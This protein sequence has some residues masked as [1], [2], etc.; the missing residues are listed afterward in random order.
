[1]TRL[2]ILS[3]AAA[4]VA[5]S[6]IMPA[7]AD[8]WRRHD[9]DHDRDRHV[10]HEHPWHGPELERWRHG[11]WWHGRRHGQAGWWWI[12]GDVWYYYP[13][14]IYP[15]PDPYVPPVVVAPAP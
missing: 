5:A 9:W 4:L 14:P 15:Y 12:V 1:M 7:A 6:A 10:E 3:V 8:E 11:T 13:A 2:T